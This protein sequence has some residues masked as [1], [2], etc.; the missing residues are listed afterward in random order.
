VLTIIKTKDY[1]IKNFEWRSWFNATLALPG[2]YSG[3]VKKLLTWQKKRYQWM[4]AQFNSN[5]Q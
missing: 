2:S 5:A 3:E 1:V 4:D